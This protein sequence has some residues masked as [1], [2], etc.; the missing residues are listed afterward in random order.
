MKLIKRIKTPKY[1]RALYRC[2]I[3][4]ELTED[5]YPYGL[6]KKQCKKCKKKQV[7]Y[8]KAHKKEYY[9]K[10]QKEH[11]K[12]QKKDRGY[13]TMENGVGKKERLY[14]IYHGMKQ[15]CYNKNS[16][17]C[18]RYGGRGITICKKWLDSYL[19]FKTWA[20][21][22]GYADKLTIDRVDNDGNYSPQNCRWVTGRINT[23]NSSSV[24]LNYEKAQE[25]RKLRRE[26]GLTYKRLGE[27]F[28]ISEST[29]QAIVKNRSWTKP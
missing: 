12:S 22:N 19:N 5:N 14:S 25:I 10:Y 2:E 28:G 24:K 6:K 21:K 17:G 27:M 1:N 9:K 29:P 23:L 15:R 11:Y 7:E 26:Q 8:F 20:N 13:I 4:G 18:H 16:K 3:C